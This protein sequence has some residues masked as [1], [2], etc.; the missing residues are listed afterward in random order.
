MFRI[1]QNSRVFLLV[2]LLCLLSSMTSYAMTK[3]VQQA[4]INLGDPD[5]NIRQRSYG[6]LMKEGDA[7]II[8]ILEAFIS[9]L[10]ENR[11]GLLVIYGPSVQVE[12]DKKEYP[13][14][15]VF[16]GKPVLDPSGR[17][18]YTEDLSSSMIRANRAERMIIL[19]LIK[20]LSSLLQKYD[21]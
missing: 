2:I 19:D 5:I 20:I 15:D 13:L 9:G 6:T 16:T 14:L 12:K 1:N 10:L 3:S 11:A 18:I 4:L 8:P 7:T 21:F 17:P